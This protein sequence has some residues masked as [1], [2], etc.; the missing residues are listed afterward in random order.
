[1]H[2]VDRGKLLEIILKSIKLFELS[3][4]YLQDVVH[5]TAQTQFKFTCGNF[6][7]AL[8]SCTYV[9]ET[10][11]NYRFLLVWFLFCNGLWASDCYHT[12]V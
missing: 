5:R 7:W 10:L 8:N 4:G 12:T 9:T 3:L 11:K 2:N 1:M 6:I